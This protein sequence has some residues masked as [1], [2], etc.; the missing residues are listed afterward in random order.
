M[1][2][3]SPALGTCEEDRGLGPGWGPRGER[4]DTMCHP[5]RVSAVTT[6]CLAVG[7]YGELSG[8]GTA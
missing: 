8:G 6:V 3:T 5:D 7:V 2:G 1:T 4:E